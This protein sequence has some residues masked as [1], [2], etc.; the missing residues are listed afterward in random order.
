MN[1]RIRS[2]AELN[3]SIN[4][5]EE[6]INCYNDETFSEISKIDVQKDIKDFS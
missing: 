1:V 6:E 4:E 5:N 3:Y 2:R